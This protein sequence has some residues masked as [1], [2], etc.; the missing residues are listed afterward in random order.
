MKNG[1]NKKGLVIGIILL[2]V[3]IAVMPSITAVDYNGDTLSSRASS[4]RINDEL[5]EINVSICKT[6]EMINHTFM[7]TQQQ[8]TES[9]I[10]IEKFENEINNAESQDEAIAIYS[11]MVEALDELG[12]LLGDMTVEETQQLVTGLEDFDPLVDIEVTVE[13][14]A[15]RALDKYDFP[16]KETFEKVDLFSDPD[17]FVKVIINGQEFVTNV[18]PNTKYIYNPNFTPTFDVPDDI[19][20]VDI[21]IQLWDSSPSG[22]RLCDIGNED[23]DV[24]LTYSLKTG[25]W[26]GDD[27]ISDPSGYGRLNG[28]DDGS[29][30]KRELDCELWFDIYQNDYDNDGIP[31]WTEVNVYGTDPEIDNTGEDADD[32]DVPIEW[33]WKWGYDPFE[34]NNHNDIDLDDDGIDNEEE[35]LV[36]EWDS[37]PFR[38]DIY[39]ELDQMEESPDGI[40]SILTDGAREL[41]YTALNRYNIALHID[42]GNMGG[43]EMIPFDEDVSGAQLDSIYWN[44]FLHGDQNN[45]R[46]SVFRYGLIVYWPGRAGFMFGSGAFVLSSRITEAKVIPKVEKMRSMVYASVYMHELGHTLRIHNNGVDNGGTMNFWNPIYWLYGPYKST[47]NYR[48]T[49]RLVDYSDGSRVGADFND[50]EQ[51]DLARFQNPW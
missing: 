12:L 37:D 20:F 7:L 14:K 21:T 40:K 30:N 23:M 18:W 10:L 13:I 38:P 45:W 24:D 2:F 42:D 35:Y 4:I 32:D 19:E 43:G 26:T 39:I 41:L 31:Y 36:S 47:M 33:E 49:Y 17:F 15:I 5:V 29:V 11:D 46:Q 28:C 9:E 51:M 3:G 1:L 44:Y 34:S 27:E 22:D 50:W 8:V 6:D 16:N 48:Y 25:H